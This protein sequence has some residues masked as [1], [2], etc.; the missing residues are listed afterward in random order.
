MPNHRGGVRCPILQDEHI[1]WSVRREVSCILDIIIE[2]L[3]C[4]PNEVFQSPTYTMYLSVV[5]QK[6]LE[7]KLDL[8][9]SWCTMNHVIITMKNVWESVQ[10]GVKS[11]ELSDNMVDLVYV[12]VVAFNLLLTHWFGRACWG[13]K[14]QWIHP[15]QRG[16]YSQ[17]HTWCLQYIQVLRIN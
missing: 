5:F 6:S 16:L 15:T 3:H 8:P 17:C 7:V 9:S 4:K 2:S 11:L 14:C 1:Q 10:S 13:Q 12:D